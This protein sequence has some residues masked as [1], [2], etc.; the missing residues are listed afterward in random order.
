MN[1]TQEMMVKK[2]ADE[3]GFYQRDIRTLLKCLN[4][5]VF[6]CLSDVTEDEDMTIQVVEGCKLT[7]YV[8]PERERVDPRDRSPIVCPPTIKLGAKYSEVFKAKIQEQY[9]SREDG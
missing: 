6:D 2:L 9:D 3:S 4:K 1:I 7:A 5:V 8:V